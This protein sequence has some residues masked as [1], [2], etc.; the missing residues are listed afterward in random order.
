MQD[1]VL[2][3]FPARPRDVGEWEDL[4]IRFELAPR[5]V[6]LALD[7]ARSGIDDVDPTLAGAA[8]HL[9]ELAAREA[10][11]WSWMQALREGGTLRPWSASW[12]RPA[13]ETAALRADLERFGSLRARNFVWVQRRGLDVWDWEAALPGG[14]TVTA[15]RLISYLVREDGRHVAGIREALREAGAC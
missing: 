11:A 8:D 14:G 13:G 10:E 2:A 15:F 1:E 5:A 6:R 3:V 12:V 7:T 4:L 9:F